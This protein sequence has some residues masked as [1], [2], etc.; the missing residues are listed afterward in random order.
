MFKENEGKKGNDL[1]EDTM[2]GIEKEPESYAPQ[3]EKSN[4]SEKKEK[5]KLFS[6]IFAKKRPY[7]PPAASYRKLPPD[8]HAVETYDITAPYSKITVASLAELGGGKAYYIDE[9]EPAENEK[10]VLRTLIDILSKE[11][12]PPKDGVDPKSHVTVEARRLA[13]K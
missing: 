6:G 8:S 5:K 13:K 1:P 11:L 3:A 10:E 2:R 4:K 9:V 7:Q 12:E